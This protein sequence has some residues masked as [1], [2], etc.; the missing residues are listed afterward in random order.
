[1]QPWP[2]LQGWFF[3]DV[4]DETRSF[5]RMMIMMMVAV[6]VVVGTL[7]QV[8]YQ[9]FATPTKCG[10]LFTPW[11]FSS[12]R[13]VD[14]IMLCLFHY[15]ILLEVFLSFPLSTP[16]ALGS[17]SFPVYLANYM[18][19]LLSYVCSLQHQHSARWTHRREIFGKPNTHGEILPP[20][21]WA[22]TRNYCYDIGLVT[23]E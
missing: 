19:Y 14:P 9:A 3:G 1:M 7:G 18:V 13:K 12:R 5:F 15:F 2:L 11:G 21:H 10:M 22:E 23:L 16:P 8:L 4:D 20:S 17:F 6:M